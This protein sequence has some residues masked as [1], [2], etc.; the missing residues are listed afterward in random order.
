M[1]IVVI[2]DT[3][4][5]HLELPELHGDVLIHCGDFCDGFQIN[6]EDVEKIDQWFGELD[7]PEIIVIGGN[8]DFVAQQKHRSNET[9]FRNATYLV[10]E[11]YHYQGVNFFGT[12]WLPALNGWAY[13]LPDDKR[14]EKWEL[15]PADTDILISHTPPFGI[16][17]KPKSGNSVGC[18][19]LRKRTEAVSP[20][21]HC[22][23]HVHASYGV[24]HSEHTTYY[25][26]SVVNADLDV[27]NPPFEFD[28]EPST[29]R[30]WSKSK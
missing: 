17:D 10:D 19:H 29:F 26:A 15:I 30:R 6:Q 28:Y 7:F 25:N 1:R 8:H 22:F 2:G 16:L 24:Y 9:V 5:K 21:V 12:P 20:D 14:K 4:G 23:G 3:H 13:Y 18:K 11:S 27:R